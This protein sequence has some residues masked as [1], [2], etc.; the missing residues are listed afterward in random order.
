MEVFAVDRKEN[1]TME[2]ISEIQ[3]AINELKT[4]YF[5]MHSHD[6]AIQMAISALQE[7][8]EREK[9][10]EYCNDYNPVQDCCFTK[11]GKGIEQVVCQK[12]ESEIFID[13]R[14]VN[15]CPK[16]GRDLRK[17]VEK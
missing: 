9:G 10:F 2:K 3:E 12:S 13:Q 7:Q 14:E 8:A 17:P 11:N 16:C 15:F 1:E 4:M 6:K 5:P